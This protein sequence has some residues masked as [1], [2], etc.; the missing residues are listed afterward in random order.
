MVEFMRRPFDHA[1]YGGWARPDAK[2]AT[3]PSLLMTLGPYH[4]F[5]SRVTVLSTKSVPKGNFGY[6]LTFTLGRKPNANQGP[7]T[8][9]FQ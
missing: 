5:K 3:F 1:E 6:V 7:E 8:R 4:P 2:V 9:P